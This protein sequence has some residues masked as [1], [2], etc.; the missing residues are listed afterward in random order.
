MPQT[1]QVTLLSI[2]LSSLLFPISGVM[3]QTKVTPIPSNLTVLG[4]RCVLPQ[5]GCEAIARNL[6]LRSDRGITNLQIYSLDLNRLDGAAVFPAQSIR[7]TI[8]QNFLQP[9]QP[10]TIP[11]QFDLDNTPSGEYNGAILLS[12]TEGELTIPMAIRVKDHPLAPFFVLLLGVGLGIGISSYRTEGMAR[13]EILVRV[14][15]LRVQMQADPQLDISFERQIANYLIDVDTALEAKRWEMAQQA[16][17]RA[18]GIWDKWRKDRQEWVVQI[19][20]RQEL[21]TRLQ[22]EMAVTVDSFYLQSM[23]RQLEDLTRKTVDLT[24]PLQLRDALD[25][26]QQQFNRY[27]QGRSK[28]EKLKQLAI[29]LP[30]EQQIIGQSRIQQFQL[31]LDSLSPQKSDLL[32]T[33]QKSVDGAISEWMQILEKQKP[34]ENGSGT[35]LTKNSAIVFP[36]LAPVP[37]VRPPADPIEMARRRLLWFNW[38]S[39]AIAVGL[40]SGTGFV[41]LYVTKPT[42]GA[43]GLGDYFVLMAW[44]FGA[45]V[46]RD[47]VTKVVRDWKLP[48]LK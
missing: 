27:L 41:Q 1:H 46:T 31:S 8:S 14:G 23:R 2:A 30:L 43:N 35:S 44:G 6:L 37:E 20:Y 4:T 9:N 5:L 13:D 12:Y 40:L 16:I 38:L 32:T 29:E 39:Y 33:W 19:Q 42:F 34:L 21:A 3:A 22:A 10:L 48:G 7:P 17:D 45:E 24:S 25:D 28:L 47:S 18:I 26:L 36:F 15:R 11:I